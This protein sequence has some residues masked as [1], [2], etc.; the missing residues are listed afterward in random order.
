[1]D[2]IT[3]IFC[4]QSWRICNFR[5][6][7]YRYFFHWSNIQLN[8]LYIHRLGHLRCSEDQWLIWR[9]KVYTN[10]FAEYI[11]HNMRYKHYSKSWNFYNIRPYFVCIFH[12]DQNLF[13]LSILNIL[14]LSI[15][16]RKYWSSIG[17]VL[18]C[19]MMQHS[20]HT[21]GNMSY[22]WIFRCQ[23]SY[24]SRQPLCIDLIWSSILMS[25]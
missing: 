4:W 9:V 8:I 23:N 22:N 25:I 19:I 7:L 6:F 16:H 17:L 21:L 2:S 5:R 13:L 24:R 20:R 1:M 11:Q 12:L 14:F 18:L 3:C 10:Y 15:R